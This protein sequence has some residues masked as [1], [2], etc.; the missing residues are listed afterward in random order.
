VAG[1]FGKVGE[2]LSLE[3]G[4]EATKLAG[5]SVLGNLKRGLGNLD[6]VIA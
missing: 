1:P 2:E 6:S 5:L 3:Q 4:Y